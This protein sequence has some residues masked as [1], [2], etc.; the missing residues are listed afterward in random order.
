MGEKV[1]ADEP[2]V[3]GQS[4]SLGLAWELPG[5]FSEAVSVHVSIGRHLIVQAE[6]LIA[7]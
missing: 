5:D 6:R 7:L 1:T 2:V 3:G 4:R